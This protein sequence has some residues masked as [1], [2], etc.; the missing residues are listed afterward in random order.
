ME[1]FTLS[2]KARRRVE[3]Q[4]LKNVH[5]FDTFPSGLKYNVFVL[6]ESSGLHLGFTVPSL[7]I[8]SINGHAFHDHNLKKEEMIVIPGCKL[9]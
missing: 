7:S 5:S 3:I 8:Q 2:E 6:M 1:C 9:Q 4:S